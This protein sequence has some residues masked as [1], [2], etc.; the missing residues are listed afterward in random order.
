MFG[1]K[2]PHRWQH[3]AIAKIAVKDARGDHVAQALVHGFGL[4]EH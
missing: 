2:S 4:I 1:R 3:V